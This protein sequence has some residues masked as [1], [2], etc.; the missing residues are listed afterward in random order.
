MRLHSINYV[1]FDIDSK[2]YSVCCGL[3]IDQYI[4][5]ARHLDR[6]LLKDH[7]MFVPLIRMVPHIRN[8]SL[9]VQHIS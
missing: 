6:M 9:L 3:R 5:C 7:E 1:S 4:Y 2:R 8:T